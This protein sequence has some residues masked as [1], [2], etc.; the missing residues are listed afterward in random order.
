MSTTSIAAFEQRFKKMEDIL[1]IQD[2][3]ATHPLAVDGGA[4]DFWM[5]HW[6]EDSLMDRPE[7]PERHSGDFGGVYGKPLMRKELEAPELDALRKTGLCHFASIPRIV[8]SGDN[9]TATNYLQLTTLDSTGY[10]VRAFLV[11]HW[12]FRRENDVWRISK[13]VMRAVGFP[14]AQSLVMSSF[15]G[16]A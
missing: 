16:K 4:N 5:D 1:A 8:I 11:S 3:V 9:A 13:R 14:E 7:D 6:T 12:E 15:P 2:L 10:R